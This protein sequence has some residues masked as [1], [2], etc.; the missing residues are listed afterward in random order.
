MENEQLELLNNFKKLILENAFKI[1]D[2]PMLN[3]QEASLYEEITSVI[4]QIKGD[5]YVEKEN[6][7]KRINEKA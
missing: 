7:K 1:G 3:E 6:C 5:S 4:H 2:T